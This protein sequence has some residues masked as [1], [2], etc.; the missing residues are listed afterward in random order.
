MWKLVNSKNNTNFN[1]SLTFYDYTAQN[2][3]QISGIV[4]NIFSLTEG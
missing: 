1:T 2:I 3:A 4:H